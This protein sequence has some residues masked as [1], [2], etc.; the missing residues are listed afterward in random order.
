MLDLHLTADTRIVS[1]MRTDTANKQKAEKR[2]NSVKGLWIDPSH[3]PT[4]LAQKIRKQP[5]VKFELAPR[6]KKDAPHSR[7]LALADVALGNKQAGNR[8][9]AS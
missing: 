6:T 3:L 1:G 8:R 5:M 7:I 2:Q 4:K 9:R